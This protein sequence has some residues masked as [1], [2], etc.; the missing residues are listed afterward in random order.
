MRRNRLF[1]LAFCSLILC[2]CGKLPL[3]NGKLTEETRHVDGKFKVLEM[4]D[5]VDVELV[6]EPT[7]SATT[8]RIHVEANENLIDN[9]TA[10]IHGDTLTIRN[11]NQA[12]WI[13]PYDYT[14][15]VTVYY[16]TLYRIIF[17]SNG[18]LHSDTLHG[19]L[20]PGNPDPKSHLYL[21][22]DGGSGD[23]DLTVDVDWINTIYN[24]GTSAITLKG[25]AKIANTSASY[26]CH[27]PINAQE[28]EAN[29]HFVYSY[30]TGKITA[31]AFQEVNAN[32]YNNGVICYVRYHTT[33]EETV[34]GHFDDEGVWVPP[35]TVDVTH[36]CPKRIVYTGEPSSLDSIVLN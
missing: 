24:W 25:D 23:I 34:W 15:V 17:N 14:D 33:R 9:I 10:E 16:D 13:R 22:V 36:S 1:L 30:G 4:L 28:M 7:A 11:E 35:Y 2:S 19:Y 27:G 8:T 12:D 6:K 26:N 21:S 18:A 31:K 3:S 29:Y 5:N 32:N 20:T